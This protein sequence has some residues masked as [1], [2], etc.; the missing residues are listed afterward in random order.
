[1][2]Y[3]RGK[4]AHVWDADGNEFIDYV[5]ARGP[6]LMGHSPQPVLEAV[7]RQLDTGLM[8]AGQHPLEIEAAEK[9]C[10]LVPC[11]EMVRFA[12]TGSEV[13]HAAIRLAR[14]VTGRTRILRFEG[15]YHGWYDNI[16]WSFAPPLDQPGPRD[17]Y[18]PVPMTRGQ[19]PTDGEHLVVR[20]WNDLALVEDAFRRHPDSIAAIITEPIMCNVGGIMPWPGFHEGLRSLCDR[21]GALLIFDEIITGFRVALGGAQEHF[22]VRPD[23]ATF[24]KGLAA[25][26]PVSALAGRAQYMKLF[27][28]TV[29]HSGTYNSNA[30]CTAAALAAMNALSAD[31]GA[32]LQHAHEMG[33]RLMSGIQ[34]AANKAGKKVSIRAMP[35]AFYVSFNDPHEMV[36]YRTF[37]KHDAAAYRRFWLAMQERGVRILPEGLWFV[38][39]AH[40]EEDV[41]RTL[42]A[43]NDAVEEV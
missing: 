19:P 22:G 21:Y 39:T 31:G 36:D 37:T 26:L 41:G 3:E 42:E 12:C 29:T 32:L 33:R 30:P 14:A 25:G 8:Y 13:V 11:A 5:L 9:L 43:V 10:S 15:H 40:T 34:E 17:D 16:L 6:L 27:D 23:L 28:G 20:P 18:E 24:A 1:M 35:T 4:D 2:F 38:S 7:H